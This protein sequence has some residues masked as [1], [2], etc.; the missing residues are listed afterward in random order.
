MHVSMYCVRSLFV[1]C[2]QRAAVGG[3]LE[4]FVSV[5]V[6]LSGCWSKVDAKFDGPS[7]EW[8]ERPEPG[9]RKVDN[10]LRGPGRKYIPLESFGC[11]CLRQGETPLLRVQGPRLGK[12]FC[13]E[14]N[15]APEAR[16]D[17][18]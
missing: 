12:T 5:L 17:T 18:P 8:L 15:N 16:K 9:A 1:G 4:V 6:R 7:S 11:S 10:A 2:A 13:C 3:S 14:G